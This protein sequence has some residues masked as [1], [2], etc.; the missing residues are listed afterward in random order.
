[1]ASNISAAVFKPDSELNDARAVRNMINCI[2]YWVAFGLIFLVLIVWAFLHAGSD[3]WGK[4]CLEAA[5]A[6]SSS[7]REDLITHVANQFEDQGSEDVIESV[8]A[9][10]RAQSSN[11]RAARSSDSTRNHIP[12]TVIWRFLARIV[13]GLGALIGG[14]LPK[15]KK[16]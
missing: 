1:M 16:E 14:L 2:G 8:D 11:S 13:V 5:V 9:D 12:S 4:D 15:I 3:D 6:G 10:I 7:A